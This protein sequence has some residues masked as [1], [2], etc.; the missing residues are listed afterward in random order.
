M[1]DSAAAIERLVEIEDYPFLYSPEYGLRAEK[2]R[3]GYRISACPDSHSGEPGENAFVGGRTEVVIAMGLSDAE[4]D[5]LFAILDADFEHAKKW[6][7]ADAREGHLGDLDEITDWEALRSKDPV[8]Y[9]MY[10]SG[11]GDEAR[12]HTNGG[13]LSR[14]AAGKMR[15]HERDRDSHGVLGKGLPRDA[16]GH[17]YGDLMFGYNAALEMAL[18]RWIRE[19]RLVEPGPSQAP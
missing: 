3:A 11:A 2:L 14:G 18:D 15:L 10:L 19:G 17:V 9:M 7:L 8:D 4:L 13:E 5:K 16:R 1:T 12:N 6:M